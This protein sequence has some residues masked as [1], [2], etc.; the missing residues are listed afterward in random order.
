MPQ[1]SYPLRNLGRIHRAALFLP[2]A[3]YGNMDS[4]LTFFPF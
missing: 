2:K 3:H 4:I 1:P